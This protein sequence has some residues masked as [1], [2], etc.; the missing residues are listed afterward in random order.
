MS[1]LGRTS[2][3]EMYTQNWAQCP[4]TIEP[5]LAQLQILAPQFRNISTEKLSNLY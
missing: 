3:K 5:A 4:A 1:A 2:Q